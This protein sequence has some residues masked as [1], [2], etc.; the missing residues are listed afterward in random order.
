MTV[1]E[2]CREAMAPGGRILV[3][4]AV[5]PRDN[6]PHQAKTLDLLLM[7]A[8]VGRERTEADFAGLF[9]AAG[10]RISRIVPTPTVLS[11]VEAVA[12]ST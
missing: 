11:V 4:D 3:V 8:L 7:S 1:L 12:E 9:A 2:R 6:A 10:L 5:V